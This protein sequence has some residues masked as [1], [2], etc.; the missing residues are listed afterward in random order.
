MELTWQI[1]RFEGISNRLLYE[2][3]AL[4]SEIFVV[5]QTC[6]YQDIDGLDPSS[7][8]IIGMDNSTL[9]SYARIVPP[10]D[11]KD[12]SVG[13]VIIRKEMRGRQIGHELMQQCLH[14]CSVHFPGQKITMSAQ[15]HLEN[16]Y[17]KHGFIKK[18]D[19]YLEDGIPHVHMEYIP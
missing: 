9:V 2:I 16:Y 7:F 8:H 3:L 6:V 15:K 4:R 13:R 17:G 19:P 18:G 1:E 14:C 11:K 12:L 10:S 5:E